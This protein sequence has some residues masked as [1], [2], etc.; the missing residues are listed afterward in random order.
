MATDFITRKRA[1]VCVTV[2]RKPRRFTLRA[3]SIADHLMMLECQER[4]QK[5]ALAAAKDASP[6]QAARSEMTALLAVVIPLL[7]EPADGGMPLVEDEGWLLGLGDPE[8]VLRIQ[9]ELTGLETAL[10]TAKP[11][12]EKAPSAE[13]VA[14]EWLDIATTITRAGLAPTPHTALNEWSIAQCVETYHR[15]CRE[16]WRDVNLRVQLAGGKG[17]KEKNFQSPREKTANRSAAPR[18][19]RKAFTDNISAF[20]RE[21]GKG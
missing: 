13:R 7:Q 3:H 10:G 21:V 20:M 12:K 14:F 9:R 1:T 15:A 17:E 16:L 2:A 8:R 19:R 4:A 11:S 6:A 18:D 5:E